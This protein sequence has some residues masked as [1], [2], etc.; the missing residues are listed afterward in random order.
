MFNSAHNFSENVKTIKTPLADNFKDSLVLDNNGNLN[1]TINM[2]ENRH[3]LTLNH[4][5]KPSRNV[6]EEQRLQKIKNDLD[7]IKTKIIKNV[8]ENT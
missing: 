6:T 2:K 1:C 5:H 7:V 4:P 8:V 3:T